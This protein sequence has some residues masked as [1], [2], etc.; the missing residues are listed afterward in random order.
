MS[1]YYNQLL[2]HLPA[3]SIFHGLVSIAF[4]KFKEVLTT[5][6][7]KSK[8]LQHFRPVLESFYA[9]M[10]LLGFIG[11][12][13]FFIAKF[14]A[15]GP[16]SEELFDEEHELNEMFEM[17]HM[18]LFLVM[19]IFLVQ[20]IFQLR[21]ASSLETKWRTLENRAMM[22]VCFHPHRDKICNMM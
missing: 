21:I 22:V 19:M 18:V 11:L 15:L 17:V 5:C 13:F 16:L 12:V 20:I 2:V 6:T 4:E 7:S 10:T 9:E 8:P 14:N 3:M 1:V